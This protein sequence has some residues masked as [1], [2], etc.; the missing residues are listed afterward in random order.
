MAVD[1]RFLQEVKN[2]SHQLKGRKLF[3]QSN[4]KL[5]AQQTSSDFSQ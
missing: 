3:S 1:R 5:V 4:S 2:L